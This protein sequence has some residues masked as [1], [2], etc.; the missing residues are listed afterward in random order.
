[1]PPDLLADEPS[2]GVG[3]SDHD[4]LVAVAQQLLGQA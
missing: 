3:S 2:A 1:M 4:H